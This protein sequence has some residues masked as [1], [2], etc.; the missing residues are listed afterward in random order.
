MTRGVNAWIIKII[1]KYWAW[2][3]RR[4]KPKLLRPF[5]NLPENTIRD[6]N[7]DDKAA[8][9]K[10]KEINEAHEVL[11]DPEKRKKYDQFGAQWQQYTARRRAAGGF[12]LGPVGRPSLEPAEYIHARSVRRNFRR[13]SAEAWAVFQISSRPSLG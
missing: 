11:S 13:C 7:P 4:R 8:E 6:V 2:I 9:E 10:F 3:K 5:E 12:R 1:I